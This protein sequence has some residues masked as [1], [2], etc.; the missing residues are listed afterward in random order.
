VNI[1]RFWAPARGEARRGRQRLELLAW[2]WS[3]AS[4]AEA[5]AKAREILAR[6]LE[7]VQ[8]GEELPRGY[9]YG[10][11]PLREEILEELREGSGPLSALVTRNAYGARVLNAARALFIDVDLPAAPRRGLLKRWLG[12]PAPDPAD[13]AAERLREALR[14][15]PGASFRI[16]RTAAGFRV[17]ATDPPYAPGDPAARALLERAGADPAFVK[18]CGAQQSFRARLTPKPWRCGR[19]LPPGRHPREDPRSAAAF[20]SWLRDYEA[21]CAS[22]ATCRLLDT[23]GPGRVHPELAPL[24]RLHDEATGVGSERPLA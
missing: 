7:R 18:L 6:V 16:Y 2:G 8:R 22:Y 15:Q 14:G 1:P 21:A 10:T 4:R 19:P 11:R 24:L 17:L 23:I 3:H 9:G 5:E 20:A 12:P 13:G